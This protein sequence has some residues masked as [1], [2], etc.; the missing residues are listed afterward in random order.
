MQFSTNNTA[1]VDRFCNASFLWERYARDNVVFVEAKQLTTMPEG[2][3]L[4]IYK[5]HNDLG[6]ESAF[7]TFCEVE[8]HHKFT[9]PSCDLKVVTTFKIRF[10]LCWDV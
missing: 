2:G 1:T 6:Y 7:G 8:I 10:A 9:L 3:A 5:A 4:T